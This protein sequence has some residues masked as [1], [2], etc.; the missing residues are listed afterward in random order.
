MVSEYCG[1]L[2]FDS[3]L[4]GWLLAAATYPSG[5]CGLHNSERDGIGS[6]SSWT[7][8]KMVLGNLRAGSVAISDTVIVFMAARPHFSFSEA[9]M[10]SSFI[11]ALS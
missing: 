8:R 1:L 10:R 6:P 7:R 2:A 11:L 3:G 4:L 9:S 5:A